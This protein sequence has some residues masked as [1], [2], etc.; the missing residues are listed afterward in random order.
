[1]SLRLRFTLLVV[2]LLGALIVAGGC[3]LLSLERSFA[4]DRIR[5][6]MNVLAMSNRRGIRHI[7][8]KSRT[9]SLQG[10]VTTKGHV[11]I[12]YYTADAARQYVATVTNG[13]RL[14]LRCTGRTDDGG[15]PAPL[16][17]VELDHRTF[18]AWP[19]H[20]PVRSDK[21]DPEHEK[22]ALVACVFLERGPALVAEG[23]DRHMR[24]LL[25]VSLGAL[26]LGG[27][28]AWVISNSMVKPVAAAAHAAESISSPSERLPEGGAPDEVARLV[29]VLNTMLGRLEAGADRERD[30]L[31]TSSHEL[32]RPLAALVAELELARRGL[33]SKEDLDQAIDLA[34]GDARVMGR[35]VDD[36]LLHARARAGGVGTDEAAVDLVELVI[37]A[38]GR[39]ERI[40]EGD[41]HIEVGALPDVH[42]FAD[43]PALGRA[44]ENVIV[45][46]ACRTGASRR[47][48]VSGSAGEDGLTIEVLND[49]APISD[50]M[51][52]QMFQ[53]FTR[54]DNTPCFGQ[55]GL[56]LPIAR[57]ILEAHDGRIDVVSP[58]E[59]GRGVRFTIRMPR[60]RLHS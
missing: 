14:D 13:T 25:W 5:T 58:V 39:C 23:Y 6:S 17:V 24:G 18:Y 60:P 9:R 57:D 46:C 16:E 36:L 3:W 27:L 26:V 1:M 44:L 35:L 49:G 50:E 41:V 21:M 15:A 40:I 38:V 43:G 54:K 48:D 42:V 47:V 10:H 52:A 2:L 4:K 53:S 31:A 28:L 20:E 11:Q 59:D 37:E 51:A 45:S 7:D 55:H 19:W 8:P 30:F 34:L 33:R 22:H 29:A 32:R 56:G 12:D